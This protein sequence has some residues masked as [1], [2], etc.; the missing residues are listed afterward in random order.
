MFVAL[1]RSQKRVRAKIKEEFGYTSLDHISA[2]HK[3]SKLFVQGSSGDQHANMLA[4][5]ER[6]HMEK[7]R[8]LFSHM[9]NCLNAE[10]TKL[11]S[12]DY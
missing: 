7:W 4:D 8:T 10:G 5:A 11:V 12:L 9:D 3:I 2:T 1:K 6:D